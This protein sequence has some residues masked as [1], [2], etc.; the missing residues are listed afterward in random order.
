MILFSGNVFT[1]V[2]VEGSVEY[3][4]FCGRLL[5]KVCPE[6]AAEGF[7][8]ICANNSLPMLKKSSTNSFSMEGSAERFC[9]R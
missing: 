8:K 2:F 3:Q 9:K 7:K 5:R 6:G 4:P 1:K